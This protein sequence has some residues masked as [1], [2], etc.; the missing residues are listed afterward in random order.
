MLQY[1]N[2]ASS[3]DIKRKTLAHEAEIRLEADINPDDGFEAMWLGSNLQYVVRFVYT[4]KPQ[5]L[6]CQHLHA[7][8]EAARGAR[9]AKCKFIK[10]PSQTEAE[11]EAHQPQG[12][13]LDTAQQGGAEPVQI[14]RDIECYICAFNFLSLE[15]KTLQ[16]N[17][18]A[19]TEL[20]DYEGF[21]TALAEAKT[22]YD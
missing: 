20:T 14:C 16:A 22:C 3:R 18:K 4:P 13:E 19:N 10:R 15:P 1:K 21:A 11:A 6:R 12:K 5:T 2:F 9:Q 8:G 17:N 7:K